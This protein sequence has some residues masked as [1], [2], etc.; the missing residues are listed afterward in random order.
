MKKSMHG[1]SQKRRAGICRFYSLDGDGVVGGVICREEDGFELLPVAMEEEFDAIPVE[2]RVARS[3][4][5]MMMI[6]HI[7]KERKN[8]SFAG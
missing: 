4:L 2:I 7:Q 5:M 8:G 1:S 3:N 6:R